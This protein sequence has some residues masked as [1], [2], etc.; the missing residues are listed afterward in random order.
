MPVHHRGAVS[1][2]S[3]VKT[4]KLYQFLIGGSL[5]SFAGSLPTRTILCIPNMTFE[6]VHIIHIIV[7]AWEQS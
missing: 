7:H 4:D 3:T 5:A 1:V 2:N 6:L